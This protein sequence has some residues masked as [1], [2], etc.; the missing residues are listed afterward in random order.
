MKQLRLKI[1]LKLFAIVDILFA[2]RWELNTYKNG[3]HQ[4][5]TRYDRKEVKSL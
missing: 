2:E 4:S 1:A 3:R 5:R